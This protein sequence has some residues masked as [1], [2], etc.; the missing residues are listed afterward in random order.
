MFVMF[1]RTKAEGGIINKT[2]HRSAFQIVR[3][4]SVDVKVY[5]S[6][7]LVNS[8][9]EVSS[10]EIVRIR[11][12]QGLAIVLAVYSNRT[13]TSGNNAVVFE[14]TDGNMDIVYVKDC[15]HNP[16][17]PLSPRQVCSAQAWREQFSKRDVVSTL[18]TFHS[19]RT[20][21]LVQEGSL[22]TRRGTRKR[23]RRSFYTAE[24]SSTDALVL[25]SDDDTES[26]AGDSGAVQSKGG[27]GKRG[28]GSVDSSSDSGK[29]KK[30]GKGKGRRSR[31]SKRQA[32]NEPEDKKCSGSKRLCGAPADK[33]LQ[34]LAD[35]KALIKSQKEQISALTRDVK[36]S[37]SRETSLKMRISK[38]EKRLE[39]RD[40][41]LSEL[42]SQVSRMSE[43]IA[44]QSSASAGF[45]FD[46][47]ERLLKLQQGKNETNAQQATAAS[48]IVSIIDAVNKRP[49]TVEMQHAAPVPNTQSLSNSI[50]LSTL[51]EL[52]ELGSTK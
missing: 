21:N 3:V 11:E 6:I 15:D 48:D 39:E 17:A 45:S 43:K 5:T 42:T 7:F 22:S 1:R 33:C 9:F 38:L 2:V 51:K 34:Q 24:N 44:S 12:T 25:H 29:G 20:N 14:T 23:Q 13:L 26:D 41:R 28:G 27:K 19:D 16:V 37:T 35:C 52:R 31:G 8:N 10:A 36:G 32:D 40:N 4:A 18:A 46:Q 30:G 49:V 47:L 50:Q